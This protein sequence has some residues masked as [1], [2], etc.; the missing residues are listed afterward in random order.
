[1]LEQAVQ[2]LAMQLRLVIPPEEGWLREDLV[3]EV[4]DGV[5]QCFCERSPRTS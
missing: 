1:L 5:E 3:V 4:A 2:P